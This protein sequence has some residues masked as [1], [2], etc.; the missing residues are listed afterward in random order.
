MIVW[1][2]SY[3]RSGNTFLRVI[4]NKTF[5][6]QTYSI[7]N[8][9]ADIGADAKTS[10]VVGHKFLPEDFDFIKARNDDEV[11]F[12][13]THELPDEHFDATDKVI[14]LIR[15]GR[16]SVLSFV[17]FVNNYGNKACTSEDVI[18]GTI[19][20]GGWGEHVKAWSPN[21]R[22][23]TLLIKFEELV[24]SPE[25]YVNQ[26]SEF[27]HKKPAGRGVPLFEELNE[28]NPKFFSSGKKD[29]WK[30]AYS[31]DEH[32]SFWLKNHTQMIEYGYTSNIPDSLSEQ[33]ILPLFKA[34]SSENTYQLKE[35]LQIK[36]LLINNERQT[37]E[38]KSIIA[39]RDKNINDQK[40]LIN[41]Q[42]DEL[43]LIK[44]SRIYRLVSMFIKPLW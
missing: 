2:A 37:S 13:K 4:L 22:A 25:L 31:E 8:D 32:I 20:N 1:L 33:S 17:K 38:L 41:A 36:K 6:I 21:K 23:N 27:I 15:D 28:I 30:T 35:L 11:F 18:Y 42:R 12:I 9:K 24:D 10:D 3:P 34:L 7:Y 43:I 5:D 14:Y 19:F 29:S 39:Q 44:K 40:Q 16:E 26:I